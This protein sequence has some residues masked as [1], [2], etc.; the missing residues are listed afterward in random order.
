M[1]W[2]PGDG[3]HGCGDE[4]QP[5]QGGVQVGGVEQDSGEGSKSALTLQSIA[6]L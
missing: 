2:L 6:V 1:L 4:P 3:H 5:A